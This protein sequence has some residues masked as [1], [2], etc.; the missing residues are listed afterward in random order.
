MTFAANIAAHRAR[1]FALLCNNLFSAVLY[2]LP[3]IE[4]LYS[5]NEP[6]N[7]TSIGIP[8]ENKTLIF[9]DLHLSF[10]RY[11]ESLLTTLLWRLPC[12]CFTRFYSRGLTTKLCGANDA[13]RSLRP[14]ERIVM[15]LFAPCEALLNTPSNRA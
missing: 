11:S 1:F 6:A 15:R 12:L 3:N 8:A 4:S 10:A 9:Q 13:D 7:P 2:Q 5:R 14:N